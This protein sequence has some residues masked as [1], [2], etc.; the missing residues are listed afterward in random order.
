[1][2]CCQPIAEMHVSLSL[3][4]KTYK[5]P[6][7]C[8]GNQYHRRQRY[9]RVVGPAIDQRKKKSP[10]VNPIHDLLVPASLP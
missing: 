1:M 3:E 7:T 2:F 6:V 9:Q 4:P 8:P 5:I 10:R